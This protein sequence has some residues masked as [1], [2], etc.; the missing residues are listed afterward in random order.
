[1]R[2]ACVCT[3]GILVGDYFKAVITGQNLPPDL[4]ADMSGSRYFRQYS[5]GA[6]NWVAR[7]G[8]LPNTNLTNAFGNLPTGTVGGVV[9]HQGVGDPP[10]PQL[11][12]NA[13]VEMLDL[14]GAVTTTGGDG[15]YSFGGVPFG[16]HFVWATTPFGISDLVSVNLNTR[17]TDVPI[18]LQTETFRDRQMVLLRGRILGEGGVPIAAATVWVLGTPFR[19]VTG[20]DGRFAL[21]YLTERVVDKQPTVIAAAGGRWGFGRLSDLETPLTVTL[22]RT[23]QAPPAPV[24]VY[25]FIARAPDAQ[26]RNET[27]TQQQLFGLPDNDRRGFARLL[28]RA[29]LEDGTMGLRVLETHPEWIDGGMIAGTYA[30]VFTPRQGDVF[31]ARIGF[32]RSARAGDV[33]FKVEFVPDGPDRAISTIAVARDRYNESLGPIIGTFPKDTIGRRGRLRLSVAAGE[34]SGQDWAVW[35][36]AQIVRQP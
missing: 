18:A 26:W 23:G 32:L 33:T 12:A 10:P 2:T 28:D 3:E 27:N 13:T 25:D 9:T 15:R 5:P 16:Q 17:T 19:A 35:L 24:Q 22:N 29:E 11:V 6:P 7:P 31:T 4:E 8:M 30:D 34:S 14:P 20:P 1:F 36:D 21:P